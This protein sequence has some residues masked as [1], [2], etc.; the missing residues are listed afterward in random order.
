MKA[1]TTSMFDSMIGKLAGPQN[2][3]LN[4]AKALRIAEK[5]RFLLKVYF[6]IATS[7]KQS[8]QLR[9]Q[10]SICEL[11]PSAPPSCSAPLVP[12]SHSTV[13]HI[14]AICSDF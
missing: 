8:I 7:F 5:L 11:P 12:V 6:A 13:E 3:R 10:V 14:L 4:A 2:D 1:S 9:L